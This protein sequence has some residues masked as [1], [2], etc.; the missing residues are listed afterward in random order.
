MSG[1]IVTVVETLG[2]IPT[3]L[4]SIPEVEMRDTTSPHKLL[5]E[6]SLTSAMK[7]VTS[8]QG[9]FLEHFDDNFVIF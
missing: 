4:A 5:I 1:Q 8:K 2:L 6:S 7:D 3:L 9:Q